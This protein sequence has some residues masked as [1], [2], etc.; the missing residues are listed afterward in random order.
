M[1]PLP[2]R[3]RVLAAVATA[4]L[5]AT[6]LPALRRATPAR[7]V[8]VRFEPP[9]AGDP[10]AP[11]DASRR[12]ARWPTIVLT[13]DRPLAAPVADVAWLLSGELTPTV[14]TDADR[15]SVV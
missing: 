9:P 3:A 11:V 6:C 14:V 1:R 5:H 10:A 12:L 2:P 13:F 15:K 7:L 8:S 4:S